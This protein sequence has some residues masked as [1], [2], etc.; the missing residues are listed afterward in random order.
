MDRKA[1]KREYKERRTQAGIFRV[2]N[3]VHN[4]SFVGASADLPAMLNRQ[5]AQLRM[6]AH[7]NR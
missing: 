7:A 2:R 1:F 5:R 6:G 4:K 3:T